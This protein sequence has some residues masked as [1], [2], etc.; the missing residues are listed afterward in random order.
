MYLNYNE[1]LQQ[2]EIDYNQYVLPEIDTKN[3]IF[4]YKNA[5]VKDNTTGNYVELSSV[6]SNEELI[7]NTFF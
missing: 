4:N 2:Y 5:Q 1:N 6:L 7:K 3:F